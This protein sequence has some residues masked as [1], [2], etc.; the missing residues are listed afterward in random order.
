MAR[1]AARRE[2][3]RDRLFAAAT[4]LFAA[5]GFEATTVDDIVREAD[6]ATGTFYCHFKSK[7]EPVVAMA[8][9][10]LGEA[11]SLMP[12]RSRRSATARRSM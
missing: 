6:V 5:H 8:P 1:Q 12:A 3:T 7:E 9:L 4:A 11:V 10:H 2:A